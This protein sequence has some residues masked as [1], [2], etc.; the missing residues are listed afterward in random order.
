MVAS[1]VISTDKNIFKFG[2]KVTNIVSM[3]KILKSLSY[4][5]WIYFHILDSWQ[6]RSLL[7]SLP[8]NFYFTQ[9]IQLFW[10]KGTEETAPYISLKI[11][12]RFSRIIFR[13]SS[14]W[15]Q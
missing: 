8:Q 15:L 2:N 12:E 13:G 1:K 5:F 4:N 11:P 10:H 7:K 14:G 6:V 3:D 9:N